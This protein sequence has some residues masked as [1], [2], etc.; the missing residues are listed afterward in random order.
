MQ[1]SDFHLPTQRNCGSSVIIKLPKSDQYST[2]E[3]EEIVISRT[4]FLIRY[5][6]KNEQKHNIYENSS[7]KIGVVQ[8][9][10]E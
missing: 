2:F 9:S 4:K 3:I 7:E 1:E 5:N 8:S 6:R 10:K